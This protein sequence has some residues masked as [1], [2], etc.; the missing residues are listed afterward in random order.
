M[1]GK[2]RPNLYYCEDCRHVYAGHHNP[3]ADDPEVHF[4]PPT[5]CRDCGSETFVEMSIKYSDVD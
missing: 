1:R 4:T 2:H 5:E 3:D